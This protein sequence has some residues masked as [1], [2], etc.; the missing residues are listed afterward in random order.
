MQISRRP[1]VLTI[2]LAAAAGALVPAAFASPGSGFT[3]TTLVTA[4]LPDETRAK[5]DTVRLR[6]KEPTDVRVQKFVFQAGGDTGWHHHPG[7]VVVAI[8][9]GSLTV[10]DSECEQTTYGPGLAAGAVFT[11][12]GDEPGK[13]TSAGGATSYV[14]YVVPS[15]TPQVFRIEDEVPDCAG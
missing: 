10:W 3:A 9:S 6:T 8:E 5:G 1:L 11:E 2:M 15:V 7:V 14:T 12:S 13:V 4:N